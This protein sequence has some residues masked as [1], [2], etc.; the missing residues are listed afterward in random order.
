MPTGNTMPVPPEFPA[1]FPL[2]EPERD[3]EAWYFSFP[4]A[5]DTP[6]PRPGA[7]VSDHPEVSRLTPPDGPLHIGIPIASAG[8]AVLAVAALL[9]TGGCGHTDIKRQIAVER[10]LAA[11]RLAAEK[12][13][14]DRALAAERERVA[15]LHGG[16]R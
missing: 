16:L 3:L 11:E 15:E 12:S 13:I 9:T 8:L 14:A 1:S 6:V 5:Q 2:T 10:V 4:T 7:E